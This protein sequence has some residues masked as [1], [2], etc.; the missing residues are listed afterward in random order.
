MPAQT[1]TYG[2]PYP[3]SSDPLNQGAVAVMN[4]ANRIEQI[5]AAAGIP[6]PASSTATGP[7]PTKPTP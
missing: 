3:V 2:L 5:L 1:P 4:L 6:V 7:G